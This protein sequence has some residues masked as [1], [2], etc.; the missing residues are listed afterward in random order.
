MTEYRIDPWNGLSEA[1][2]V[3]CETCRAVAPTREQLKHKATVPKPSIEELEEWMWEDG[4]CET[5][6]GCWVEPDGKCEHGHKS[7]MLVMGLI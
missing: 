5:T 6:D 1:L 4:G 2:G 7:W 3:Q